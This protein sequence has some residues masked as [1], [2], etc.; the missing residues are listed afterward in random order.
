MDKKHVGGLSVVIGILG[1]VIQYAP[2]LIIGRLVDGGFEGMV[3]TIGTTGQTVTTYN[4]LSNIAQPLVLLVVAVSFGYS[5]AHRV[6]MAHN[7]RWVARTIALGS[8]GGVTLAGA[9]V[10]SEITVTSIDGFSLFLLL[11]SYV[12]MLASIVPVITVGAFA[13]AALSHFQTD[14]ETP[15]RPVDASTDSSSDSLSS[16]TDENSHTQSQTQP[17]Q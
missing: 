8:I 1:F 16:S 5:I 11:A 10:S 7:Y 3:P 17:I 15:S 13:G 14:D 9:L 4:L 2:P 6:D 12:A